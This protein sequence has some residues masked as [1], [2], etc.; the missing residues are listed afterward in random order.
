[1]GDYTQISTIYT[2]VQFNALLVY[3]FY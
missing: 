3:T 1:M 2:R